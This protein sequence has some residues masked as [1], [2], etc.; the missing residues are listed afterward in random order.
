MK[1]LFF[2]LACTLFLLS[3]VTEEGAKKHAAK[4]DA[5]ADGMWSATIYK[6][7]KKN[8]KTEMI[9]EWDSHSEC[10]EKALQYIKEKSYTD[11]AYSCGV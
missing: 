11:G 3:C 10:A 7:Q 1:K 9:G 8:S 5:V 2:T 6:S 4:S